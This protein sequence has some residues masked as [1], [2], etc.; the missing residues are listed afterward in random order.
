MKKILYIN[1]NPQKEQLSY[2]RR[3][4]NYMLDQLNQDNNNK[5]KVI[6]VYESAIPFINEDVLTAWGALNAGANFDELTDDQQEKIGKMSEIL[7]EFKE[8][9]EY[10]FVTPMWNFSIPPLLKAYIDNVMIAGETFKYTAEGPVGLL[11]DKKATII[12][13]S[14]GVYTNGPATTMD[15][16]ANY[17]Q[18]VLGFMGIQ[19]LKTIRVEGVAIPDKSA[20]EHLQ[21]AF[22]NIDELLEESVV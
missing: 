4:G 9:D 12:L 22:R 8:A 17:I 15:Y 14:G 16:A 2:S 19:D 1:G 18:T 6:D 5:I 21:I 3:V 13:A 11:G 10:I 7:K 20:Q